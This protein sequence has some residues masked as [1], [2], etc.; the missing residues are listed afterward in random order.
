[1]S[2]FDFIKCNTF[3]SFLCIRVKPAV[4]DLLLA[5][6]IASY[7]GVLYLAIQVRETF[8][9][10][11]V[12]FYKYIHV[13]NVFPVPVEF[14]TSVRFPAQSY[15]SS[16]QAALNLVSYAS[17]KSACFSLYGPHFHSN[18]SGNKSAGDRCAEQLVL[19]RDWMLNKNIKKNRTHRLV[20]IHDTFNARL[21]FISCLVLCV[22]ARVWF[23]FPSVFF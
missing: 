2:L 13:I 21:T 10:H 7:L 1:M 4:F 19:S 17:A 6:C 8:L 14:W 5:L 16:C 22:C 11:S 3:E 12:F 15:G 9:Q 18:V 23:S 20:I